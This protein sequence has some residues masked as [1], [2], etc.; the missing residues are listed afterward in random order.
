MQP[1]E[2]KEELGAVV[3]DFEPGGGGSKG[4]GAFFKAVTQEVLLSS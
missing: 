3:A 2:G 4:I 1:S